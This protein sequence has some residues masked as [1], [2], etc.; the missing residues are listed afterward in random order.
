EDASDNI[1]FNSFDQDHDADDAEEFFGLPRRFHA[2]RAMKFSEDYV[3]QPLKGAVSRLLLFLFIK[4]RAKG[5]CIFY[6]LGRKSGCIK[7]RQIQS[8]SIIN[9]PA[10]L[11][12]LYLRP[13]NNAE[14][15]NAELINPKLNEHIISNMKRYLFLLAAAILLPLSLFAQGTTSGSI[16]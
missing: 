1:Q 15:T 6:L 12:C 14:H 16:E 9:G 13:N 2:G 8:L 10:L 4:F 7:F 5:N 11:Y 3:R